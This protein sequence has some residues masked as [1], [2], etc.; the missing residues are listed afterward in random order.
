MI[1]TVKYRDAAGALREKTL[2]AASRLD[3]F[4]KCKAQGIVPTAL[5]SGSA[6]GRKGEHCSDSAAGSKTKAP[7]VKFVLLVV[8]LVAIGVL[9]WFWANKNDA[10]KAE[11]TPVQKVER[12]K[13]SKQVKDIAPAT[14]T[15]HLSI[16]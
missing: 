9:M 5:E 2:E 7:N 15:T 4:A 1:F 6:A 10:G 14:N 11:K 3:C 8:L 16:S 13:A 12:K